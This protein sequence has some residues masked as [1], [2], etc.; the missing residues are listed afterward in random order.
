MITHPRQ[1][2]KGQTV[3]IKHPSTAS[4]LAAW[5][6]PAAVATAAPDAPMPQAINGVAVG[7]WRGAP[8]SAAGWEALVANIPF[9]EPP[10]PSAPGKKPAA[11]V[12][13]VEP[14]GRVWV[15]SPTNGFGGYAT[16]FPKGKL[17]G[18]SLHSAAIKEAF[19]ESGLQVELAGFLCD[20]VRSTSVTRYYLARRIGGS[21]AAMGWESQAVKLV[22]RD[23]LRGVVT[24]P[25]DAPI[26]EVLRTK[27]IVAYEFGL[28]S[29]H[30][31]LDTLAGYFA[32]FGEWPTRLLIPTGMYEGLRNEILGPLGWA[33]LNAR[34]HVVPADLPTVY[35]EGPG[36]RS[37][38]YGADSDQAVR[39]QASL[40]LWNV[41]LT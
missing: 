14:D 17:D 19:E 36:D 39:A 24:H 35:A 27:S 6:D 32:K 25:N 13:T 21:P 37:H 5:A 7:P 28:V 16:T 41:D 10:M 2:D 15:V 30:R 3:E 4:P 38:E 23:E 22:P 29:G 31:M 33:M 1:D 8:T 40:W 34:L 9:S 12:V 20:S 11:G 26:L 18:L